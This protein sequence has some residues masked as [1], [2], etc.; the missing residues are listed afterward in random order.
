M[1]ELFLMIQT[2]AMQINDNES[3]KSSFVTEKSG[4]PYFSTSVSG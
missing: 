4:L 3:E 2:S 1:Y